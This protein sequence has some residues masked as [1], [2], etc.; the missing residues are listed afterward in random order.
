[1]SDRETV[2]SS[3]RKAL[4]PLPERT[5]YPDWEDEL[6]VSRFARADLPDAELFAAQWSAAKGIFLDGWPA[7]AAFLREQG[8]AAGY[9]DPA[10]AAEAGEALS[11]F[12]L[13]QHIDRGR[14]DE[15]AFSITAASGAIAESGT[16]ILRDADSPSRLASLAPWTHVAVVR[17]GQLVRTIGEAFAA[18]GDDPSIVLV[19]GPSKTADIEGILIQGVHGPGVQACLLL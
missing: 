15:Y 13:E 7:L 1:M 3:I 16:I 17:R 18:L 11:G 10:L 9:I 19:T 8:A 12:A 4:E 14:I 5:P 6:A 2:F